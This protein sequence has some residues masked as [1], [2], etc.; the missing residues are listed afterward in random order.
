VLYLAN[1]QNPQQHGMVL[2]KPILQS[3]VEIR[4]Y[5]RNNG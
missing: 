3:E 2:S 5:L 1:R 4:V